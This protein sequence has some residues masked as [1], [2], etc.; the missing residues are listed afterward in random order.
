MS[1]KIDRGYTQFLIQFRTSGLFWGEQPPFTPIG[2]GG[3]YF[4]VTSTITLFI[5]SS[6][7]SPS[8]VD[9][10]N[11]PTARARFVHP[12][13]THRGSSGPRDANSGNSS[14][15]RMPARISRLSTIRG[16]G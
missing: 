1:A 3:R 9:I 14:V 10:L 13:R 4:F 15:C 12:T 2:Y 7:V 16:P 5:L 8:K 11:Q 6:Y